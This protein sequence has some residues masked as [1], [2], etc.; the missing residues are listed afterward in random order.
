[1]STIEATFSAMTDQVK[2]FLLQF[3]DRDGSYKYVEAIDKMLPSNTTYVVIDYNDL[4]LESE[5][6][7]KF[8][9]KPDQILD[10]F[11]RAIKEILE[12]KFPQHADKI[13]HEIR[14]RIANYPVQRSLRQ[15]NA[16]VIGKLTS[17]S[18]MV[19]RASE[20]KPLA[21]ELMFIC[22]EGHKT[23]LII[24]EKDLEMKTPIQ[25]SNPKCN[26]KE[27][28][29]EPESSRFI[30]VQFVRLQELPEDL[31]PGQL[32]HYLDVTVKQ[33]LV[34][35]ARPGDRVVLTG[36]VRIEPER[37]SGMTRKTTPV[38]RLRLSGN[39]VEFLGGKGNK[40]S[41]RI[42][43][44]QISP[45]EE[46]TIKSLSQSTDIY[47]RLIGSFAPHIT[48]QDLIKEAVL[49]LMVGSTQRELADGAKIRGDINI[50][51]V[52][53]PGTAKS[54]ILKFTSR[55]APRGLYTSGRGATAAGLTAAVVRD[56]NGIFMLEAGA[57][58]LG[59][60]G[61]VSI[62]EF[63]KMKPEDRSALHEV[64]E[65]QTASIAKGGIV[66][67]L[68]ARCSILAAANP[69]YGKYDRFKNITENVNLPVP[70]LT[71]F[72]LIFVVKDT[73]SK[74]KDSMIAKHIINL[75]TSVGIDSRSLIE[76]EILT[77][78]L[79]YC[80]R[81]NPSLSK[82][83][84]EKFHDYYLNMR[85]LGKD[86]EDMITVTPRQLEGLI[87]IGTARARLL[88]KNKVEEDD[89]NRAIFLF[90]QMLENAGIDVN[91]GKVDIGVLQG[92][93][94]SESSKLQV[95]ME[96][97]KM[98]EGEPKQAVD[99]GS[100]VAELIKTGKFDEDEAKKYIRK[101]NQEAAIVESQPGKY[102][103]I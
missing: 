53:D 38:Y 30:D 49:L 55:V 85:N 88:M 59:D 74:E 99:E 90:E 81:I 94:R 102:N 80:K 97:L 100:L 76:P 91:T 34:D 16:E 31:P 7:S 15:I 48:G 41:R 66:A 6:E 83:A 37:I 47:Q 54:E 23:E 77:K 78:Y 32:P 3:K 9:D 92:R 84:E 98:L 51:L 19:L 42:E 63:D 25:C 11:G 2:E 12:Q 101:M 13:K 5:I 65:Q 29:I 79:S 87:R 24:L 70:L 60:Q 8:T 73:P 4:V 64:M 58:V 33:D 27:L 71:R 56:T 75:H 39:N 45:E 20:V 50:F 103:T 43:R 40:A 1:M 86:S 72:D 21:K 96:T 17:V 69:M 36:I 28:G 14:A 93:S 67:T 18:G 52:G 89:A 82:E 22:P 68:N 35:Y 95:F 26:H 62:D 57:T 46:K 10:A 44:E 61:I